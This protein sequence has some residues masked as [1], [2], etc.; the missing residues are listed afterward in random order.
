MDMLL[1]ENNSAAN[2]YARRVSYMEKMFAKKE[3]L[4]AKKR[5]H[6]WAVMKNETNMHRR[7]RVIGHFADMFWRLSH[8]LFKLV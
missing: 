4:L 7:I 6:G 3:I 1:H 2:R 5:V 8:Q